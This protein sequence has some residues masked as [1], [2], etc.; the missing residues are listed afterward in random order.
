VKLGINKRSKERGA[1]RCSLVF[2]KLKTFSLPNGRE[3]KVM[4]HERPERHRLKVGRKS[5]V[6]TK[7]D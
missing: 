4:L 7:E 2:V 5:K 3:R 6:L 1:K